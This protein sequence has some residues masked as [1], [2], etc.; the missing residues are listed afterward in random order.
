MVLSRET[1]HYKLK[2]QLDKSVAIKYSIYT[3]EG[4]LCMFVQLRTE[5]RKFYWKRRDK[6][7]FSASVYP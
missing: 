6:R 2:T 4:E 1:Q 5:P 3:P 7:Y